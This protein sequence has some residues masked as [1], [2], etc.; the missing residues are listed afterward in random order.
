MKEIAADDVDY[1]QLAEKTSG[2]VSKDICM[3]VN[4]AARITGRQDEDK[5]K[6]TTLLNE[7]EKS[8]GELPS[9]PETELRKHEMIRDQFESRKDSHRIGF[10]TSKKD[11]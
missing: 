6:M 1:K 5:I 8:K 7:I 10:R 3:L 4:R 11:E 9:V 2:Y